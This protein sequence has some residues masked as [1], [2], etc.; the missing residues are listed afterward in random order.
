MPIANFFR[1]NSPIDRGVEQCSRTP[2]AILLDVRSPE[3]YRAGHIPASQ[4][5]PLPI[6]DY[7]SISL[8]DKHTPLFVYCHSGVRS[9]RAVES[10]LE[11]GYTD[12]KNIGGIAVYSGALEAG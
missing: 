11:Q 1:L 6:I 8:P 9:A 10:L 4:N 2:G 3:E 7:A 12:V 5:L